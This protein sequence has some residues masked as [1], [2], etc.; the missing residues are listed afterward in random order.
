MTNLKIDV[1][2][3]KIV[4]VASTDDNYALPLHIVFLSILQNTSA[5]QK[6]S[7]FVIDGGVQEEKK[8]KFTH[9]IESLGSSIQFID[10]DK[11][12]YDDFPTIAHISAPAYYRIS[13]PEIFSDNVKRAIY[14]DCDL[15]V[16]GDIKELWETDLEGHALAAAENIASSTFLK[17]G[18]AQQDY[19]NSGVLVLDLEKWRKED[20]SEK[21]RR[22]KLEHPELIQTNDQCA[23]N[24][25]FRGNWKRLPLNWNMQSGLYNSSKQKDRLNKESPINECI[26]APK[27]IHYVGWSK[28]W[29]TPCFH[30]LEGEFWRYFDQSSCKDFFE[31]KGIPEKEKSTFSFF[32]KN[33]KKKRWQKKYQQ[34]GF[35]LYERP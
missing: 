11:S 28:P 29:L 19:F 6:I 12:L 30:P 5:P 7:L 17:S 14:L 22:F 20:L 26:L 1:E 32:K 3:E 4:V 10:F 33:R 16:K 8:T 21:V 13:I 35:Q 25:V 18:L 31:E 2:A 9:E 24:G 15:I 34:S 27:I 23:F